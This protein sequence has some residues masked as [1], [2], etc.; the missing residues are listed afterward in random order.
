MLYEVT[1]Q[2]N[3]TAPYADVS[4]DSLYAE[5]ITVAKQVGLVQ[6]RSADRFDPNAAI[7]RVITS[8]SI[9]YTKLYECQ[10][11]DI[12]LQKDYVFDGEIIVGD[13]EVDLDN[14]A[15]FR[16]IRD[17]HPNLKLMASV[18]GW[19]WSKNFSNMAADEIT[20]RSFANSVVEFLRVYQLDGIDIDWEYP[21]EGG[22]ESNSRRPEDK[23]N[24]T[25]MMS[26]V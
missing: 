1:T 8:Y 23:Q 11:E 4:L 18:G 5:E 7:T 14:F 19:S 2:E 26:V 24:F 13:T 3:S 6:G 22:E 15:K 21:V 12:P 20:R 17:E 25:L 9:H 16:A 10:N